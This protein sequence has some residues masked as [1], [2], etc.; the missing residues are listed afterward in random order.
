MIH[1]TIAGAAEAGKTAPMCQALGAEGIV[2]LYQLGENPGKDDLPGVNE[3]AS[4]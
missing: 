3:E 1:A 2:F 4:G